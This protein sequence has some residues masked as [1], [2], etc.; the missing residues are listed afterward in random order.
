[1]PHE[2]TKLR[3]SAVNIEFSP[4]TV[5][6]F[7][8]SSS[9]RRNYINRHAIAIACVSSHQHRS[10]R[11]IQRRCNGDTASRVR[12]KGSAIAFELRLHGVAAKR[13]VAAKRVEAQHDGYGYRSLCLAQKSL[14]LCLVIEQVGFTHSLAHN[15]A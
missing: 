6:T 4:R 10:R 8:S 2:S 12:L 14:L 9:N 3:D 5:V 7:F 1:M 13:D 15:A 11:V